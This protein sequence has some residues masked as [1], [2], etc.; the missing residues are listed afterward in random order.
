MS[1]TVILED[2]ELNNNFHSRSNNGKHD[3]VT[4]QIQNPQIDL[5]SF[6]ESD[7]IAEL[8]N[9]VNN[10]DDIS[11]EDTLDDP[12]SYPDGGFKAYL[13]L[14]G[15]FLGLIVNLGLINSIGAVQSYVSNNILQNYTQSTISWIFSIYLSLAY[16]GG[17]FS[18]PIFDRYGTLYLLISSGGFIFIG[19]MGAA[20]SNKIY[21]F[22]LSFIALGLGNGIGMAPL[23]SVISHFFFNKRGVCTGI[24]TSGGS[25]GGLMFPL[26]LRKLYV[27]VGY[28]WALRILGFTCLGCMISSV[29]LVKERFRRI[30]KKSTIEVEINTLDKLK[31]EVLEFIKIKD[32]KFVFVILGGFFAEFSL[33]LI[34]TYFAN[35]AIAQGL[36]ESESLLLLTI[37][38]AVGIAG[39][40]LPGLASDYFGRFNVNVVMLIMYTLSI[41]VLLLP[42]GHNHKIL[43]AF[44]V[45][46]GI[47]SGCIL[48][49]L[50][51]CLSQITRTDQLGKRY[52]LLNF[53]LSL[54]NLFGIPIAAAILDTNYNNLIIFIGCLS[55]AGLVFWTAA[56]VS[57]VGVKL[58]VKV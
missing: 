48:T 5:Q 38:N 12:K 11:F 32:I 52:G 26:M 3:D 21:Q 56:R 10:N 16:A 41:L 29:L 57:I 23:V 39:R 22:I 55:I 28:V 4:T 54:A 25:V 1:T 13:T 53:Y 42:F 40:W 36:S 51:A 15:C 31:S 2:I 30:N 19:L 58:N 45:L 17:I 47:S 7:A 34:V 37:W 33:V 49:L 8:N 20:Q 44:A 18:G 43:Y 24:A 9:N 35:Y 50:P 27:S 46:G 6:E 14:F